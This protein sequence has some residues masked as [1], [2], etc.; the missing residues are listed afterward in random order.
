V[1]AYKIIL[2]LLDGMIA[3]KDVK[4]APKME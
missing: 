4:K 2:Q 3:A 1:V